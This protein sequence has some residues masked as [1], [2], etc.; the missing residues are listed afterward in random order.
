M[1]ID[2][3]FDA[4]FRALKGE[5]GPLMGAHLTLEKFPNKKQ[6]EILE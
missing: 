5:P 3:I 4:V 1:H 2:T 6:T